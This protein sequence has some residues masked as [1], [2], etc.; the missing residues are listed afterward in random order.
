MKHAR[1]ADVHR[2]VRDVG[3]PSRFSPENCHVR[4][5]PN[6]SLLFRFVCKITLQCYSKVRSKADIDNR[7][8]EI[9]SSCRVNEIRLCRRGKLIFSATRLSLAVMFYNF[10]LRLVTWR[11][12]LNRLIS[13]ARVI[14]RDSVTSTVGAASFLYRSL[15]N[16]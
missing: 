3:S 14:S 4:L 16:H 12:T 10:S 13:M 8:R 9:A 11:E 2:R 15:I 6:F 5:P 1:S 7:S